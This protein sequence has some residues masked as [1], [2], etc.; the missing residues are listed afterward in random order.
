MQ[1]DNYDQ[2]STGHNIELSAF[3]DSYVARMDFEDNFEHI[4]NHSRY[5]GF[6]WFNGGDDKPVPGS[7][8]DCLDLSEVTEREARAFAIEYLSNEYYTARD[9]I[10]DKRRYDQTWVE[11]ATDYVLNE[12]D[13]QEYMR[14]EPALIG[15][16]RFNIVSATGYSQGDY[17]LIMFDTDG[18]GEDVNWSD[19]FERYLYRSPVYAHLEIDGEGWYLDEALSD[20]YAWDADEVR[21]FIKGLDIEEEAKRQA[22]ELIPEDIDYC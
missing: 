19:M 21:E 8:A 1:V 9:I 17:A 10:E 11:Y 20:N 3:Y 12:M 22:I 7:V 13:L 5:G 16:H 14:D 6:Y 15:E 4:G 18:W 2:S